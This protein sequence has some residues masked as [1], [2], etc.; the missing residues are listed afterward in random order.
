MQKYAKQ[1][2]SK[3]PA[4]G[5]DEVGARCSML[6]DGERSSVGGV[7]WLCDREKGFFFLDFHFDFIKFFLFCTNEKNEVSESPRFVWLLYNK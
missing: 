6:D 3:S 1:M 2:S 7:V 5:A 4:F